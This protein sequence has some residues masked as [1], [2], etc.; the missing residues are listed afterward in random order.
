M[1]GALAH[2]LLIRGEGWGVAGVRLEGW[3]RW[4][5]H[6]MVVLGQ[7][8]YPAFA[9]RSS[10]V[11]FG[12]CFFCILLS[13]ICPSCP[14]TRLFLGPY[15]FFF[16]Y[17]VAQRDICP[18]AST[19]AKGLRSQISGPSLSPNQKLLRGQMKNS[20]IGLSPGFFLRVTEEVCN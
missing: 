8:T 10:Q 6:P 20:D 15:E 14:C 16:L 17:F 7:G 2:S 3:L 12:F 1:A 9:S 13:R 11:A 18:C 19:A 4:S 5:A